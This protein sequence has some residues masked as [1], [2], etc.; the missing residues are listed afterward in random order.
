M[1]DYKEN[2]D[3]IFQ[4]TPKSKHKSFLFNN[5]RTLCGVGGA[6]CADPKY[7]I[8]MFLSL[9]RLL[10]FDLDGTLIDSQIDLA[11]SVNAML[12]HYKRQTL[13]QSI[14][15][16]YIGDGVSTL[17][18]RSLAHA[19]LAAGQPDPHD[20]AAVAEAVAWFIA[21]Y[22]RHMLEHT[23]LYPGVLDALSAMRASHPRLPMALLTNKPVRPSRDICAHFK[24]NRFF[25]QVYGGNSFA[26]KKPD[27]EGL[28]S[29]IAEASTLT[30]EP[31]L[32]KQT[33]MIGDSHVDVQTARSAGAVS[34]G[35]TF[36]L[37]P[38]TLAAA[39]PD[40]SVDC[41]CEWP[42]ALGLA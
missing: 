32:P 15:S 27:P 18:R 17:V 31:I 33:V 30:G 42:Q 3:F 38:E 35:C 20:D 41:A 22:R 40:L 39:A 28:R 16:G 4:R 25:F 19:H 6:T 14:I 1:N 24:L 12:S 29:L 8:G 9:P 37:S 36:G 21:S 7:H 26:S 10:V 2:K 23:T 11:N 34:L 13:A 5:L